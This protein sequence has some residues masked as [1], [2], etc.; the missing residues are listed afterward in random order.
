MNIL[1]RDKQ[2]KVIAALTAGV[3]IRATARLVGVNRET[4]G[5]LAKKM[6]AT[7][8]QQMDNRCK[9]CMFYGNDYHARGKCRRY[10]PQR[11]S[12]GVDFPVVDAE[13]LCGEYRRQAEKKTAGEK[14]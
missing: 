6:Q 10:P 4:V 5:K 9:N 2:I 3:G 1:S 8:T 14:V 11:T 12:E 13:E 7:A